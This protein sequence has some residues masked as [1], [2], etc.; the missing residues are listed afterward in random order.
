MTIKMIYALLFGGVGILGFH[1]IAAGVALP[2]LWIV[3][4]GFACIFG[5]VFGA[6]EYFSK[7]G[8]K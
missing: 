6:L 3:I 1:L 7:K 8:R 5:G 4:L 2:N